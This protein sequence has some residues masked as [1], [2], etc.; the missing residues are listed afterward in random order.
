MI[1]QKAEEKDFKRLWNG[2]NIQTVLQI[3]NRDFFLIWPATEIVI[4]D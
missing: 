3:V 2:K 1:D 4:A